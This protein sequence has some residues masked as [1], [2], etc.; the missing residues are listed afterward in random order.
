[1]R[2]L[3]VND[4]WGYF[5]GVEQ[6]IAVTAKGLRLR[7]HQCFLAHG[8][9]TG[10]DIGGY[11]SLFD[12]ASKCEELCA[13]KLGRAAHP[14]HAIVDKFTPDVLYLHKFSNVDFCLPYLSELK[15]VRMIHD[16][17]L[18][19]PR[20]HKYFFHNGRICRNKAGWRC[21]LDLAFLSRDSQLGRIP[22]FVSI[23]KKLHEM[24]LNYRLDRLLVGSRFMR[25]ELLQ[26][27]F[28]KEKVHI[29]HPNVD[30]KYFTP[31]NVPNEPVILYVGQLIKGKGVDLLLQAL[32]RLSVDFSALIIGV[33]NA[34]HH[35]KE[36]ANTLNL[37]GRVHFQG[38]VANESLPEFYSR[39][40][41]VTV[42]CRWPEPFGMIGLEAMSHGRPVVAFD[43]G[44]ISDWLE[45]EVTGLLVPEQD[46]DGLAKEL[47]RLLGD[48][49]TCQRMGQMAFSNFKSKFSFQDYLDQITSHLMG[50]NK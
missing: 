47:T 4:K 35:L 8:D 31:S 48:L 11:E 46:V 10:G 45:H 13:E 38:W 37:D 3:F 22:R 23:S 36:L 27:G 44:G 19:C 42:P 49:D 9:S 21:Y 50:N 17:D 12:G 32:A 28:P 39:A 5:G 33:G 18:C 6:N 24:R 7:G 20:R 34:E 26:N 2:I 29:V 30:M 16:H 14:F 41:I 40:R 25:D 15:I 1:V 43:V